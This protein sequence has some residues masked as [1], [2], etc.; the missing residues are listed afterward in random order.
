MSIKRLLNNYIYNFISSNISRFTINIRTNNKR[1]KKIN[2]HTCIVLSN[3]STE[4]KLRK[5]KQGE[6]ITLEVEHDNY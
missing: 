4:K 1:W 5:N 2:N 6:K 3:L